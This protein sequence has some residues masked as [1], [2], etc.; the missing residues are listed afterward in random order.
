MKVAVI[1]LVVFGLIAAVC[2]AVLIATLARPA[3]PIALTP[4]KT[5]QDV[6]VLIAAR[7]LQPMSVIDST[8]V[9]TK[10]V[11]KSQVPP[12]AL[13]NPVQVVGKVLTD[14]MLAEQLFTKAVFAREG[15]G[16][17][18]ATA[19]PPGK[20]AMSISLTDWSGMAGLLYPGSVVDVLVS[21]KTLGLDARRTETELQATTLLQGLQVMAIGSQSIADDEYKDKEAG[22]LAQRGQMNFRMVTL[23]VDPKQAEILQ[24][25]MQA[26]SISLAM[27]NP[28]D[29]DHEARRLTRAR[30][31][32]PITGMASV[33]TATE[34]D[35]FSDTPPAPTKLVVEPKANEWETI[36]IRGRESTI[37]TFTLPAEANDDAAGAAPAEGATPAASTPAASTPAASTPAASPATSSPEPAAQVDEPVEVGAG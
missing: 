26:G 35:P 20:R 28:L 1:C 21:Y 32:S 19:V 33:V 12:N 24:L 6:D 16:V 27:R 10:K 15:A 36:I 29:A 23:L 8:A 31:I 3:G 13:L 25:A 30:E 7:E 14:R 18:L 5:E 17:Y 4:A 11:P 22:A 2:A 9:T 34:P 37:R